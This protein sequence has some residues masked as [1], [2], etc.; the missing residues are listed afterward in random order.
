MASYVL[1]KYVDY[2]YTKWEKTFLRD[3]VEPYTRPK[4]FTLI[5]VTYIAAFYT[6]VIGATITEQL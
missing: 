1:R 3:M 4:S 2:L 6:G 5:V